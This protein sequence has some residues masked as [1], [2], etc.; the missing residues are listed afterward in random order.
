ME[1]EK[2]IKNLEEYIKIDKEMRKDTKEMS[3][4]DLF[5]EQH[6]ND[7]QIVLDKLEEMSSEL[8]SA[9]CM[10]SDLLLDVMEENENEKEK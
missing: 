9:N 2:A 6:I 5:C 7:I 1:L 3:D 10:I 8:Y 4:F